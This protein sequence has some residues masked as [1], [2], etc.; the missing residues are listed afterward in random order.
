MKKFKIYSDQQYGWIRVKKKLIEELGIG[1]K[2]STFS[3]QR[4][5]D[6]YLEEPLD[7]NIF[8]SAYRKKIGELL[9]DEKHSY[10]N[11]RIRGYKSYKHI[12]NSVKFVDG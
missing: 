11:S 5:E 7:A 9:F 6:V 4:G 3:Y 10:R 8:L 1:D 2:I 12:P